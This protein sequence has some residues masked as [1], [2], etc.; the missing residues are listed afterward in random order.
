MLSF[1]FAQTYFYTL[2]KRKPNNLTYMCIALAQNLNLVPRALRIARTR[3]A[4]GTRLPIPKSELI[5]LL[6]INIYLQLTM[7]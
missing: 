5:H 2:S 7:E 3:R 6:I 1:I 4:L